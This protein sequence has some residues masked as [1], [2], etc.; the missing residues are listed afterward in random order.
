MAA[1]TSSDML[2]R[3]LRKAGPLPQGRMSYHS[4]QHEPGRRTGAPAD[5]APDMPIDLRVLQALRGGDRKTALCIARDAHLYTAKRVNPSIH[6]LQKEG[7][8]RQSG[9]EGAQ[10]LWMIVRPLYA[11][12]ARPERARVPS[13]A[14]SA[15]PHGPGDDH[16]ASLA[17]VQGGKLEESPR[18][19][20]AEPGITS[21]GEGLERGPTRQPVQEDAMIVLEASNLARMHGGSTFAMMI[22][23]LAPQVWVGE[24]CGRKHYCRI[25][26][27]R[28]DEHHIRE[29]LRQLRRGRGH[30]F[31][32]RE[33]RREKGRSN[34]NQAAGLPPE[35]DDREGSPCVWENYHLPRPE[36]EVSADRRAPDEASPPVS[37][38]GSLGPEGARDRPLPPG[39]LITVNVDAETVENRTHGWRTQLAVRD[40]LKSLAARWA[41]DHGVP[42]EAVG[43]ADQDCQRLELSQTPVELGWA[44]GFAV[45]LNAFP[46]AEE[47][48]EVGKDGRPP[49]PVG[50]PPREDSRTCAGAEATAEKH[51]ARLA[52]CSD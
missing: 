13:G 8:I 45:R 29:A 5:G 32:V 51:R 35:G 52:T 37:Q 20:G 27:C 1:Q 48:M 19:L 40:S 30:R 43:L 21:K 42:A 47:Y 12:L 23:P 46:V 49:L 24:D 15:D 50:R 3:A 44:P 11:A 6:A 34:S 9:F 28:R 38:G 4:P 10:P 39:D 17:H 18:R 41:S 26:F 31:G 36:G 14:S 22:R 2:P 33:V 16:I 7:L 25:R